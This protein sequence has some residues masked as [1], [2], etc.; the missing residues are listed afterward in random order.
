MTFWKSSGRVFM[1]CATRF[2]EL[3]KLSE[4]CGLIVLLV[5]MD[6]SQEIQ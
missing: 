4:V 1:M 5:F 3:H 6:F 2:V